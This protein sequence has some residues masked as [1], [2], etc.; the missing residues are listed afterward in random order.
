MDD[1]ARLRSTFPCQ[2]DGCPRLAA[3]VEVSRRGQLLVNNEQATIYRVFPKAQGTIRVTGF[4]PYTN[5]VSQVPN[6]PATIR[7]ASAT[8]AG[9]LRVLDES[10]VPFYCPRCDRSFCAEHWTLT[11]TFSWG[12][13][14]YSGTCPAGHPHVI[15]HC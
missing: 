8:D 2:Y 9:A 13:D 4:L 3:V 11:P 10:W 6:L 7:A 15:R 14:H 12:F 1:P 5:F